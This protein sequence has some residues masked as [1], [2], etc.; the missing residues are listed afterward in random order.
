MFVSAVS[1]AWLSAIKPEIR[2]L[3]LF[4]RFVAEFNI[5]AGVAILVGISDIAT[6]SGYVRWI[7]ELGYELPIITY[8]IVITLG[9]FPLVTIF[10]KVSSLRT[11]TPFWK[12]TLSSVC[13]AAVTSAMIH[14]YSV[15]L[16]EINVSIGV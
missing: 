1:G 7:S 15:D 4:G 9:F 10:Y 11:V 13:F 6:A 5:C 3:N 14:L 16:I 8:A 12:N 2:E